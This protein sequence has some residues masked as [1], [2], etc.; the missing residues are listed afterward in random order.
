MSTQLN[1]VLSKMIAEMGETYVDTP[2]SELAVPA[3]MECQDT[4]YIRFDVPFGD[5]RFGK[6]Y[7]CTNPNCPKVQ[8]MFAEQS[9]KMALLSTWEEVYGSWTFKSYKQVIH[10][11]GENRWEGKRGAFAASKAFSIARGQNFTLNQAAQTAWKQ[12]WKGEVSQRASQSVILTGDVGLG[13]TGLAV[14]AVNELR[15]QSQ[16]VIFIRVQELIRRL[17]ETYNRDWQGETA[18]TRSR[19][20]ASVPY[21]VIDE[22]G[23]KNFSTDRLELIENI[24]RERDRRGLPFMGTTNLSKDEFYAGWQPQIADI[25]AKAHWVQIGGVKLRQTAVKTEM[26]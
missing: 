4:G 2:L 1:D 8:S 24:I 7:R 21:L 23:M 13:K 20:Y 15:T 11:V 14:A 12:D 26:W 16:S 5:V 3:C 9:Q 25:V 22:F 17:Q 18:D 19:F 6:Q 10:D